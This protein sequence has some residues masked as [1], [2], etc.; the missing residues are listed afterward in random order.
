MT[1]YY[2]KEG[3]P[4]GP[5]SD[6]ELLSKLRDGTILP[7]TLVWRTGM[8]DWQA[9]STVTA[10]LTPLS[11]VA[12][13]PGNALPGD[14]SASSQPTPGAPPVL[15]H[16]FCTCCGTIIPADQLVRI[17]GR[18]IC[19]ACKPGYLQKIQEGVA[20]P[21]KT[22]VLDAAGMA[23]AGAFAPDTATMPT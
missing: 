14:S 13:N 2:A 19:A 18:A 15:P 9:A 23:M 21:L 10:A 4:V 8:A 20:A 7:T 3:A 16:F 12:S 22:P 1:W 17:D 5:V 6:E 11:A